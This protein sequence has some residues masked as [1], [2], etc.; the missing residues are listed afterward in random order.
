ME[1]QPGSGSLRARP[2]EWV[3]AGERAARHADVVP[4]AESVGQLKQELA[5]ARTTNANL[6]CAL[7][8]NRRIGMA[9]GIVMGRLAVTEEEAFT[10]LRIASQTTNRKLRDV[11]ED[12]IYTGLPPSAA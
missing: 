10:R 12:V 2:A 5:Q 8:T 7:Q 9:I 6:E 3:G 11:A 1:V 4:A